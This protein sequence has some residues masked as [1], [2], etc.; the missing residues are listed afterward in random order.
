MKR[1]ILGLKINYY[2]GNY[3]WQERMKAHRG[4][5]EA[6]RCIGVSPDVLLDFEKGMRGIPLCYIP[7]LA[8]LYSSDEGELIF[9]INGIQ[10]DAKKEWTPV[11]Y[12]KVAIHRFRVQS[13]AERLFST[14]NSSSHQS[15]VHLQ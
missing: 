14:R 3:L 8:Q 10:F 4:H 2:V 15:T 9:K 12:L 5:V 1:A 7:K 13:D 6:A 11:D